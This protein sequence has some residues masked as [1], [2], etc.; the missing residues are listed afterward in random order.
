MMINIKGIS[1]IRHVYEKCLKSKYFKDVVVATCDKEIFK[2]ITDNNGKAVMTSHLHKGCISR[3]A[4]AVI[5]KNQINLNDY[6][7]IVQGDEVLV[8]YKLLN[9]LCALTK[10]KNIK[11]DIINVVS[12]IKSNEEYKSQSVVK[13]LVSNNNYIINMLRNNKLYNEKFFNKTISKKIFRQTGIILIKKRFLIKYLK[14]KRSFFEQKESID[15]LRFIE[16]DIKI[17]SYVINKTMIGIDTKQDY[18][19]FLKNY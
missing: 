8:D 6:I 2:E 7:C 11:Y 13:A 17:K 15:M 4:E 5:K 3:I 12:K 10:K 9:S 1:L 19:N 18:I 16:N 14:L